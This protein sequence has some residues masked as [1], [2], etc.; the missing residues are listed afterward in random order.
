[1]QRRDTEKSPLAFHSVNRH[2]YVRRCRMFS[3]QDGSC[4][5]SKRGDPNKDGNQM[6]VHHQPL[7]TGD[8]W[9]LHAWQL[10]WDGNSIWDPTGR[11]IAGLV[12]FQFPVVS[13]LRSLEF[14]YRSTAATTGISTWEPDDF[15]RQV[16]QP[17][18]AEIWTFV[19]S[20][21]IINQLPS[22]AG[23]L[24]KV[25]DVLTFQ[26]ITQQQFVGGQI[27]AWNPYDPTNPSAFFPQSARDAAAG[28]STFTVPLTSWM[29]TGFHLKLMTYGA[30]GNQLW[31][32]D[33]GNRVWR[34]CDGPVLWLKS[35]QCDLRSRPLTLSSVD[36]E[37]LLPAAAD[38]PA[39]TLEDV[40]ESLLLPLTSIASRPY[41]GSP[42][43]QV[44]SYKPTIYPQAAYN[45]RVN[46]GSGESVPIT[47]AFPANPAE[48]TQISRFALGASAWLVDFPVVAASVTLSIEPQSRSMFSTGV[49]VQLSLGNST[50]YQ[51]VPAD[52]ADGGSWT[53]ILTVAQNTTTCIKLLPAVGTEPKPYDWIDTSRYFTPPAAAVTVFTTEGVF[54]LTAR[55]K[56]SFAD[57]APSRA[58]LMQAAFGTPIVNS[59]VFAAMEMPH[60]ATLLGTDVYFVVHAPHAIWAELVLVDENLP[61]RAVRREIPMTLTADA[62]YWWCAVPVQQA[63]AGSRYHFVL[64]DNLEVMDPAS[65][66]VQDSGSF[67]V[68]FGADPNDAATSWSKVLDIAAI[69]AT[70][71]ASPWQTMSW[72]DLVIYEMHAERFTNLEAGALAPLDLLV[73]E[74]KPVSRLGL[75]GYLRALPVTAIEMMPVQEF[76]SALSWG[77]DPSF[78]FAIDGH[79][80]GSASLANFVNAAHQSGRAVF[81]DVVYNHS[82]GSPLMQIAPDVYRN[83][84]YDGDRMNCG[85]PMVGEHLRQATIHLWRTFG[86]DGFRFDD[87]QTIATQCQGG[88]G[89]LSMLR[90][91]IRDAASAEGR[92][93]PYCVAENSAT[94]PWDISNPGF[95]VM[96][97]QWGIDEAYR[98]R[99][100]SYDTW[101][102]GSD[103]APPVCQEMNNPAYWGRPYFQAVRFGE[104]HDMVSAQDPANLRIAARP[105]F[106]DGLQLAK[107]FG[108]L[109]LL[110]NGIPMLFM[111]QEVGETTPFAFDSSAPALNP[112]KYDIGS[113]AV[114]ANARVLAWFRQL[115][116]L[117]NDPT[118]GLQGVANYQVVRVGN[119]TV[120]FTC[121]A[122]QCLFAVITFG[123]PDQQQNSA[124][125][126]LPSGE[127]FKEIFNS[128]WP[129]FQVSS[130]LPSTNGGYAARIAP[131]AILNLPYIGAVVLQ[132]AH[133]L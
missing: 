132:R 43:F 113:A 114:S 129:E 71:H 104:S 35:G 116:G 53:A 21:R 121:G 9:N 56:T 89:F 107:A 85:H 100:A 118:Q 98:L 102:P 106:G 42:L 58:T 1:V 127:S 29:T 84:N 15:V 17:T 39:L 13:D 68:T 122:G 124:W 8:V 125:L 19:Q 16:V 32:A 48:L 63:P 109:A 38:V 33:A 2:D 51:N 88:W 66:E 77:Y 105:P 65:R 62:R 78:Y 128:S 94:S 26:E 81:L 3:R 14:K 97:G 110:S 52:N 20:A 90:S 95:G 72:Q 36:L 12:D 44:A 22:P 49:S 130:E 99:D 64:N 47:R 73:D 30:S 60:G 6:I 93:W 126:G 86:I 87:T 103:D 50:P 4:E 27:Y 115:L 41:S 79:Y 18:S 112:Q 117:R 91:S 67:E 123:T 61:Q 133:Y 59:G 54:G 108:T 70:A 80:G 55:A 10:A 74:L 131:G 5:L 34:P 57:P 46:S 101:H 111:G 82:L 23:A 76:S 31:E 37:I 83:G 96:D 120:A 45:L 119:R 92:F 75:P 69:S 11:D 40:A 24:F 25:G 28:I 7:P